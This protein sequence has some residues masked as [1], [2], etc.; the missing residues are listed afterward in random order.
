MIRVLVP[1]TIEPVTPVP[2]GAETLW[3]DPRHPIDA[4]FEDAEVLVVWGN[5]AA[6]LRDAATRLR[7]LRWVQTLASGPDA[8]ESAGFA[9]EVQITSGRGLQRLPVAEHVLAMILAAARRLHTL[10]DAQNECR[11]AHELGGLQRFP[12]PDHVRTVYGARV[13]IVGYGAI[14]AQLGHYLR[15]LGAAVVGVARRARVVDGVQVVPASSLLE[16]APSLDILV[17]LLPLTEQTRHVIGAEVLAALPPRAWVVNAGRGATLDTN[18]LVEALRSGRIAGASLDVFETEPLQRDHPL[19]GLPNAVL[20]PHSA[21]GRPVG[22]GTFVAENVRRY[23]AGEP[24]VN[25][26]LRASGEA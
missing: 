5:G 22:T 11:W 14:G 9:A 3:Y 23:V 24:L 8:V 18:A 19:W 10:R 21:G 17:L 15:T 16:L 26:V 7:R 13:G 20:S 6:Q 12:D 1:T 4:A 25:V 2:P